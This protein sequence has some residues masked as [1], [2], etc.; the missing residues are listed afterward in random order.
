M[1]LVFFDLETGGTELT[2]PIIQI[3]AV[4]VDD[5]LNELEAFERKIS[6]N[7]KDCTPDAL[8][9]NSYLPRE[10]EIHAVT[11]REALGDFSRFLTRYADVEMISQRTGR[12]YWV[13]QLAGHNAATFDGPMLQRACKI[14]GIFMPAAFLVLDTLQRAMWFFLER[15]DLP[16]PEHRRLSCLAEYFGVKLDDAHDALADARAAVGIHRAMR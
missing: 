1:R 11:L 7:V 5:Q 4:A 16:K 15:P 2:R 9:L 8:A 3:G 13:A 12:P 10:W 14:E 6:F